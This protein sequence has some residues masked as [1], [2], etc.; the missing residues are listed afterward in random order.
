MSERVKVIGI[1]NQHPDIR[2]YVLA[3]IDLAR[4]L[5]NEADES[6]A[7]S[8]SPPPPKDQKND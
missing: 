2:L 3:L 4:Q 6:R 7:E 8:A 5:Q 1:R